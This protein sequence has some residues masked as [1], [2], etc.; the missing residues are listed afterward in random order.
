VS[1]PPSLTTTPYHIGLEPVCTIARRVARLP[2]WVIRDR[3]E[4][5]ASPAKSAMPPKAEVNPEHSVKDRA[6]FGQA[7]SVPTSSVPMRRL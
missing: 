3:V 1:L 4:P 5:V 2:K 6:P 7:L